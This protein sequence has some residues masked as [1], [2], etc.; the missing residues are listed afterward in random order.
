MHSIS[1]NEKVLMHK[2][3]INN[4]KFNCAL[5][6]VKTVAYLLSVYGVILDK[7]QFSELFKK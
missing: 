4:V 6:D 3:Y 5:N 2:K 7:K 1:D